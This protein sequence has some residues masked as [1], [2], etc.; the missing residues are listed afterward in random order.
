MTNQERLDFLLSL[1]RPNVKRVFGFGNDPDYFDVEIDHE[2]IIQV[3][4]VSGEVLRYE[5]PAGNWHDEIDVPDID[6]KLETLR[7]SE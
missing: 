7:S 6:T 3:S 4:A 2:T 5:H 1:E